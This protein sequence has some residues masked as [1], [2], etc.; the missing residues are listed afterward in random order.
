MDEKGVERRA[1][2]ERR[3]SSVL[4]EGLGLLNPGYWDLD[5]E[6][7]CPTIDALRN[8]TCLSWE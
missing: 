2:R 3:T 1:E 4:T 5:M 8:P 7:F 6:I